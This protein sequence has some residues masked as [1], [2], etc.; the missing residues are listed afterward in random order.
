MTNLLLGA[1]LLCELIRIYYS[2][3]NTSK[4]THFKNRR[5]AQQQM[6]WDLEFKIA[7]TKQIRESVRKEYDAA[8]SHLFGINKEI[9]GAETGGIKLPEEK[10]KELAQ[11]KEALERDI[12][13]F[14]GA[15]MQLDAE[16]DGIRPSAE[17]PQGIPGAQNQIDQIREL[18]TMLDEYIASI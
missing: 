10:T 7:K 17:N 6:I 14:E 16:I 8:K 13:R 15:L 9:E 1:I 12:P 11:R 4:R 5:A 18:I 3:G 2:Y